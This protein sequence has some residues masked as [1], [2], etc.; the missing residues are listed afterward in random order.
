MESELL[1]EAVE[2]GLL[3]TGDATGDVIEE[4]DDGDEG[5]TSMGVVSSISSSIDEMSSA[6]RVRLV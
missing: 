1:Q 6:S 2:A 3:A 5:V 4:N